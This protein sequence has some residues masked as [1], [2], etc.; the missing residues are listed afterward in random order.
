MKAEVHN[1]LIW[2][3]IHIILMSCSICGPSANT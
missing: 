2:Y 1:H 3:A